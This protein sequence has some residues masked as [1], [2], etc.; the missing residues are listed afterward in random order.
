MDRTNTARTAILDK[1]KLSK[2]SKRP[3]HNA[4]SIFNR[5]NVVMTKELNVLLVFPGFGDSN[6]YHGLIESAV[7]QAVYET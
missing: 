2:V 7:A 3:G 1:Y 6:D 5:Y 4:Y